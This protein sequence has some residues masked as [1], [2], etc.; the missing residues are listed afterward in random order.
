MRQFQSITFIN[1]I[2]GV[3]VLMCSCFGVAEEMRNRVIISDDAK[4]QSLNK[5]ELF[6]LYSEITKQEY[7]LHINAP[8]IASGAKHYPVVFLLDGGL[9]FP[10][11]T[12]YHHTLALLEEL[13]AMIIVG[14]GY[15]TDNWQEGN[16]RSRDFTA[17]SGE[18]EHWGGAK[19][20]LSILDSEILPFVASRYAVD[21]QHQLLFGHSLGG[22][23]GLYAASHRPDLFDAIIVNNPAI[24]TNTQYF[25]ER[26]PALK[27]TSDLMLFVG[28]A[29]NDTNHFIEAR[30]Q[31]L[32]ALATLSAAPW[33]M[34]TQQFQ[35]HSHMSS[36]P[37][38]FRSGLL[39]YFA[40]RQP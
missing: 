21:S 8:G 39:W 23:F 7:Y 11:L 36:I 33:Q 9:T 4:L 17:P 34:Q 27:P 28:I 37:V 2:V 5:T 18:R 10:M 26:L 40:Q 22:Q 35:K 1:A 20:F 19:E 31:W 14:I 32:D 3:L 29:E 6:T 30:Q 16:S 13:P 24:H 38:T 15:G 12:A 25:I